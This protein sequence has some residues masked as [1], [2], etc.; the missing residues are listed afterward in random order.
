[1]PHEAEC[2]QCAAGVCSAHQPEP[3]AAELAAA[4][5]WAL[6][7]LRYDEHGRLPGAADEEPN[8]FPP[9]SAWGAGPWMTEPDLIEWRSKA[10]APFPLLILRGGMGQLNGYVGVPPSHP[11]H[12]KHGFFPG[13]NW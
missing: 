10:A 8:W 11:M 6:R 1:M 7:V 4:Y 13:T 12:G 2:P 3:T 9:R 5:P